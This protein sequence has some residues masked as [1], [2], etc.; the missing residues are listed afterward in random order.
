MKNRIHTNVGSWEKKKE[1]QK[2]NVLKVY[3]K[4]LKK[5]TTSKGSLVLVS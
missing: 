4:D 3:G 2:Q 5:A 1:K